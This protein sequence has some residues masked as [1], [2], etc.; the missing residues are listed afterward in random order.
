MCDA[1]RALLRV[2]RWSVVAAVCAV[3]LGACGS[4]T[5]P[6]PVSICPSGTVSKGSM[7]ATIDGVPWLA[8]C[9]PYA[10]YNSTAGS[11]YIAGLDQALDSGRAQA[12][13][14]FISLP[15]QPGEPVRPLTPGTYQLGGPSRPY[16]N[17]PYAF[18]DF[19]CTPG[20]TI[21]SATACS[22]WEATSHLGN[23]TITITSF[24]PTGATGT[25]A[26]NL[27]GGTLGTPPGTPGTKV[28]TGGTFEVAF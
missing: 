23:G 16:G 26:F 7:N 18:L 13:A 25:F 19:Y 12:I 11:L 17:D 27:V 6:S 9:V 14:F 3:L 21:A 5:S 2:R 24:T 4:P 1:L 28:V 15:Q 20:Q 10:S 22:E 8:G